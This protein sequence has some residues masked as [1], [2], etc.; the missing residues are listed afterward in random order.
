MNK[1]NLIGISSKIGSDECN[2]IQQI[3]QKIDELYE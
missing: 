2:E 3:I 1:N